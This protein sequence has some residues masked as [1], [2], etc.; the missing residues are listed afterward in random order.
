MEKKDGSVWWKRLTGRTPSPTDG[1][2]AHASIG[3]DALLA[4]Q[5]HQDAYRLITAG[6][7][8]N[9]LETLA[10]GQARMRALLGR[11]RPGDL[12]LFD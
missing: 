1:E 9:D 8:N 2:K 12:D 3:S 6:V 11:E 5:E 7:Q 10:V 4:A